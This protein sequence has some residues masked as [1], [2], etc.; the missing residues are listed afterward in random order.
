M[1]NGSG[2][3]L[4]NLTFVGGNFGYSPPFHLASLSIGHASNIM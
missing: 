3:F 4:S 1:E 2:G